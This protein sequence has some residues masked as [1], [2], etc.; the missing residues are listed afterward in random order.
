[1][2]VTLDWDVEFAT[3]A[4]RDLFSYVAIALLTRRQ[5]APEDDIPDPTDRGGWWGDAYPDVPGDLQGSRLWTL[6]GKG[7]N[8]ALEEGPDMVHEALQCGIEDGL[9][10]AIHPQFNV[11]GPGV[12]ALGVSLTLPDGR[13]TDILGPWYIS[14]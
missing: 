6:I 12:L 7:I 10:T 9:F 1:M 2:T 3:N 11:L 13:I 5:A 14:T 8:V 4:D